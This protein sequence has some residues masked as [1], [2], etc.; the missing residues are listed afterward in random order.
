[1]SEKNNTAKLQNCP[2]CGGVAMLTRFKIDDIEISPWMGRVQWIECG[3]N[4]SSGF[5]KSQKEAED[6]AIH[7]W[8]A[9]AK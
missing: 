1:M 2:F 6:K 7:K 9:R 4:V 5:S 3:A 8:E